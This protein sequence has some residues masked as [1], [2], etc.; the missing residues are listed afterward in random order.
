MNSQTTSGKLEAILLSAIRSF[1]EQESQRLLDEHL[2]QI[3]LELTNAVSRQIG[4]TVVELS[5]M[6][7]FERTGTHLKITVEDRRE[8]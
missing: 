8:K 2:K 5:S 3:S 4:K 7:S 1:I 6:L